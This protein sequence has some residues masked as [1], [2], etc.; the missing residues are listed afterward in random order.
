MS[1]TTNSSITSS[2]IILATVSTSVLT[3][4]YEEDRLTALSKLGHDD[5]NL[6][7][8]KSNPY[9]EEVKGDYLIDHDSSYKEST[10]VEFSKKLIDNSLDIDS[11]FV[12]IVNENFWDL[13]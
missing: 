2:V 12:D 4:S 9:Y 10:I 11:E 7:V 3:L 6:L 5:K 8:V 1:N 13:I